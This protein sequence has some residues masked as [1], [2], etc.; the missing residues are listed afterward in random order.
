MC[1]R[2]FLLQAVEGPPWVQPVLA[3]QGLEGVPDRVMGK[4]VELRPQSP[5]LSR[6]GRERLLSW[7]RCHLVYFLR[8]LAGSSQEKLL[9]RGVPEG[10]LGAWLGKVLGASVNC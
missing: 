2:D 7:A 8:P 6:K 3:A 9:L 4:R 1:L 10:R 5:S